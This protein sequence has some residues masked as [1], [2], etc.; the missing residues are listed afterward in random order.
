[1]HSFSSINF[2]AP[3][4]V[5]KHLHNFIRIHENSNL[6]HTTSFKHARNKKPIDQIDTFRD[7]LPKRS[8]LQLERSEALKKHEIWR[9]EKFKE[10]V[11]KRRNQIRQRWTINRGPLFDN[12]FKYRSASKQRFARRFSKLP[13]SSPPPPRLV[14]YARASFIFAEARAPPISISI[15]NRNPPFKFRERDDPLAR[16]PTTLQHF[17]NAR[18]E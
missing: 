6:S 14:I 12:P 18:P 1:M 3:P 9:R 16:P 5:P 15:L 8:K 7:L 2:S 13:P 10:R 4:L 11:E 17:R